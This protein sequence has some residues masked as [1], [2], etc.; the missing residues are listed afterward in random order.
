MFRATGHP[1]PTIEK[2]VPSA[3]GVQQTHQLVAAPPDAARPLFG[4]H[5]RGIYRMVVLVKQQQ[6]GTFVVGVVRHE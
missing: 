1:Q 6:R 2:E 3:I 5:L 4:R